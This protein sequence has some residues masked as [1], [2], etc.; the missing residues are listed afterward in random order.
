MNKNINHD[1]Y[2]EW[3]QEK[4]FG[5]YDSSPTYY[6]IDI[7]DDFI[8]YSGSLQN[9]KQVLD[10]SYGGLTI[11]TYEQLTPNMKSSVVDPF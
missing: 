2:L 9:C 11:V 3:I 8:L 10:Q 5:E 7:V 6:V 4:M 1:D